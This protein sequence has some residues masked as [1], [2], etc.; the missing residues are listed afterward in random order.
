MAAHKGHK[1]VGGRK[2]G[3][4]NKTTTDIKA[5]AQKYGKS[6]MEGIAKLANNAKTPAQTRLAAY[7]M[8]LDR[9]YG[10]PKQV[11]G[12]DG[13][14]PAITHIHRVIIGAADPDS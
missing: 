4:L 5:I 12:G 11:V 8:L 13:D 1:K 2:K 7:G 10:K 6:S 14:G 9:G 3:T